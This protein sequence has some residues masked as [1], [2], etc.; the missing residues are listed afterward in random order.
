MKSV[1]QP[2]DQHKSLPQPENNNRV[3]HSLGLASVP[4]LPE[5]QTP[6]QND[7][8]DMAVSTPHATVTVY[9]DVVEV[10][11]LPDTTRQNTPRAKSRRAKITKFTKKSRSRMFR[12]IAKIRNL[13]SA[14]WFC[15]TYPG[16]FT[17]TPEQ[18]QKHFQTF[19]KRFMR[20]H[21][22]VGWIWR[23]ELERRKSGA[24]EGVL[25][26]H[27]HIILVH[28]E[29]ID[30]KSL[31]Q[32]VKDDWNE[33]VAPGDEDHHNACS[34]VELLHNRKHVV[35]Y[36]SKYVGKTQE[37]QPRDNEPQNWGR[38]WGVCGQLDLSEAVTILI[39]YP[40]FA[41]IR[42][43]LSN[44]MTARAKK[45]AERIAQ[46]KGIDA[47]EARIKARKYAKRIK[48]GGRFK[49]TT[50]LG[51]GDQSQGIGNEDR[52]TIYRVFAAAYC[53]AKPVTIPL[54]NR[55]ETSYT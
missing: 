11:V 24:S 14:I 1:S 42:R 45:D 20:D 12:T 17:H 26:P 54:D 27:F 53:A 52:A 30:I 44:L 21:P 19:K 51:N 8:A 13:K 15:I 38:Y 22:N 6:P 43:T 39:D 49:G 33:I 18:V 23:R 46:K 5:I 9:A 3:G 50:V 48:K 47:K 10:K 31:I 16:E 7:M 2:P 34:R 29:F 36:V 28:S 35:Q 40:Q 37:D 55:H 41:E 25:V 4:Y 32:E